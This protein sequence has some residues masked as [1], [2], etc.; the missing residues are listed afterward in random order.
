MAPPRSSSTTL[1]SSA[2]G[3]GRAKTGST[4]PVGHPTSSVPPAGPTSAPP[5]TTAPSTTLPPFGTGPDT[6]AVGTLSHAL[7]R[8]A[9]Y[10]QVLLQ[11]DAAGDARPSSIVL[12]RLVSVL[13]G[14]TGKPVSQ[15]PGHTLAG[16][17]KGCW[18]DAE[19]A[20][21]GATYRVAHTG[22]S[23]VALYV[24]FL[25]GSYCTDG[26][27][28]GL[29]WAAS[30]I[31]IFT[32]AAAAAAP[33]TVNPSLF[34]EAVTTHELGHIFGLVNIGYQSKTAHEDPAHPHHS[35]D[36]NGVMYWTIDR[37]NLIQQFVT[38]PPQ[39]F[40]PADESDL[41]GLRSGMY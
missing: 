6:G 34:V 20:A 21:A 33:L 26:S 38:G 24:L 10:T 32:D 8:P 13:Q 11:L 16:K 39:D 5:T 3:S 7:L 27:V 23:N 19:I 28:I 17:G 37:G 25:D 18:R 15:V 9:P 1:A 35:S 22:G 30:S 36:Q 40:D 41:A 4:A 12:A 29:A 14:E 31:V 2:N